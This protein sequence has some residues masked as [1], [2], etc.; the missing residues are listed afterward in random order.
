MLAGKKQI[1]I[2]DDEANLRRLLAA[3]LQQEGYEAFTPEPVGGE[4]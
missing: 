3:Q 4:A 1:L 2:S